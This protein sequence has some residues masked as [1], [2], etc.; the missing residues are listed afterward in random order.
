MTNPYD[1]KGHDR[2]ALTSGPRLRDDYRS[3]I[4]RLNGPWPVFPP[5]NP[6]LVE[7]DQRLALARAMAEGEAD[8][9]DADRIV[10]VDDTSAVIVKKRKK[11]APADV[12]AN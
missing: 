8:A 3:H 7:R 1:P 9:S 4:D 2:G 10:I 11:K 6:V 5:V 12:E